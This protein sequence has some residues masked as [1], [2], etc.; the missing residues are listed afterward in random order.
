MLKKIKNLYTSIFWSISR[1]MYLSIRND[2]PSM[3]LDIA[4]KNIL[5]HFLQTSKKEKKILFDIGANIGSW[6]N[7]AFKYDKNLSIFA[8][9]PIKKTYVNLKNNLT[10]HGSKIKITNKAISNEVGEF[11]MYNFGENEGIN[12]FFNNP[13]SDQDPKYTH[14]KIEKVLNQKIKI[15][16]NPIKNIAPGQS[17]LHYSPGIPIRM[18]VINPKKNEAFILT[19]KRIDRSPNYYYLS[20]N[21]NLKEA[22]KNLYKTLRKIKNKKFKSIAVEK[23]PNIGFGEAIND[24]LTRAS[25]F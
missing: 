10:N 8:F 12:S 21:K 20:K 1:R 5:K 3:Q 17:K 13:F 19:N 24:R 11:D 16:I 9:E 6:S 2:S 15:D 25:K 22:A 4:E 18:N 23:I 7:L 14:T